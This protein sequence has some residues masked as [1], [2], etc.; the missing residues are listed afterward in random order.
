MCQQIRH[1]DDLTDEKIRAWKRAQGMAYAASGRDFGRGRA[2]SG[3][4]DEGGY[5]GDD[6]L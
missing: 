5:T 3:S 2:F 1:W 4:R 6:D